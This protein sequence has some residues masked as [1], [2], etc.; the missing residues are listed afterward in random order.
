MKAVLW[1]GSIA[2]LLTLLGTRLAIVFMVKHGH[3]QFIRDDGPTSHSTKRGTPTMG[4]IAIIVATVLA[5]GAAHLITW[6]LPSVS[7]LLVLYLFAG[8]GFVGFLDDWIK[9]SRHRSLGLKPAAKLIGQGAVAVSFAYLSLQF[10][11][12]DGITPASQY[13]SFLRDLPWFY[14]PLAVALI[15]LVFIIAALSNAVNLTDGLDGLATGAA[16][17]VFAA[18]TLLNIW[19]YNQVCSPANATLTCY[20]VRDPLDLA[21][22]SAALAG[23]CFGF[24]WWN[25]SPAKIFMGDTGA[26]AI[27]G[28]LAGLAICTRTELLSVIMC[29]LFVIVTLSVALQIGYFKLT[30]GKRLFKMAPLQHHFELLGWAEV[31]I[32][33]RF[34]IIAGICVAAAVGIFYAEWVVVGL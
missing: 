11:D 4:G 8:L 7:G 20:Q 10:P 14:L 17:F 2:F 15:W 24:L 23:A 29:G 5:Y 26:L 32:V 27:G 30:H 22:V 16:T 19:Q 18:Y 31:T 3:G 34:W 6:R 9:I 1:G 28:A 13:V 33:T 21:V 25:A 12:E